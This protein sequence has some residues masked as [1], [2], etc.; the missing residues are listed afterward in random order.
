MTNLQLSTFI[1]LM[2][3]NSVSC[4][5]EQDTGSLSPDR[6]EAIMDRPFD[7]ITPVELSEKQAAAARKIMDLKL[8]KR[9]RLGMYVDRVHD[10]ICAFVE[11]LPDPTLEA[12]L[13]VKS[14]KELDEFLTQI[15]V[16]TSSEEHQGLLNLISQAHEQF[17]ETQ[18]I[19]P[20]LIQQINTYPEARGF[21]EPLER[22]R[23][24]VLTGTNKPTILPLLILVGSILTLAGAAT[25]AAV[26][27]PDKPQKE[28]EIK[29]AQEII[30]VFVSRSGSLSVG[31]LKELLRY[32]C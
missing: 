19:S 4:T 8:P 3:F 13:Q 26:L 25:A 28:D 10:A 6:V 1:F 29:P 12:I 21:Y 9:T 31:L 17:K 15:N 16:G 22:L 27:F 23:I 7:G 14:G 32:A 20:D 2:L 5:S 18:N 24:L 30:G 11:K